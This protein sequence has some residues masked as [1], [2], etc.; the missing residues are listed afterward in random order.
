MAIAEA[1]VAYGNG[2]T[3]FGSTVDTLRAVVNTSPGAVRGKAL[4]LLGQIRAFVGWL[5]DPRPAFARG[6]GGDDKFAAL[7]ELSRDHENLV[8]FFTQDVGVNATTV[9]RWATEKSRPSG[10]LGRKLVEEVEGRLAAT[11]WEEASQEGLVREA[12]RAA[13][14]A[15][16]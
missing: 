11:L 10:F 13:A 7:I 5:D 15:A 6:V 12:F 8:S 4:K 2:Q 16:T 9:W 1:A 3:Q 14:G